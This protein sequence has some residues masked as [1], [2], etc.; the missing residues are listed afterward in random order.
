MYIPISHQGIC[1]KS[2][3]NCS[4]IILDEGFNEKVSIKIWNKKCTKDFRNNKSYITKK[5][6]TTIKNCVYFIDMLWW[7]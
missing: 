4:Y 2:G 7:I 5:I 3:G 1:N 6:K